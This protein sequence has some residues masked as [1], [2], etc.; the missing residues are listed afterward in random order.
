MYIF[1]YVFAGTQK[2]SLRLNNQP[3]GEDNIGE[4]SGLGRGGLV[5]DSRASV[6]RL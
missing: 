2:Y 1:A 3:V 4:M 5:R 6:S